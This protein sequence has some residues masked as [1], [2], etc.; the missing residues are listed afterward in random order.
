MGEITDDDPD[1]NAS[2]AALAD[3]ARDDPDL[4]PHADIFDAAEPL[5]PPLRDTPVIIDTDIGGDPD[6]A[7]ALIAAAYT[8]PTLAMVTTTDEHNGER[9][10]LARHLLDVLDRPDVDVVAG[11]P[12]RSRYFCAEGLVPASVPFQPGGVAEAVHTLCTSTDGPVR[13]VGMGPLSNL[14]AVLTA[15]PHLAEQLVVTQMGGGLNYRD[16]TRAEHNIRLDPDAARAALR[17]AHRPRLVT[18][19]VTFT[20]DIEITAGSDRYRMLAEADAPWAGLLRAHMD[21]WFA[22]FHPGTMQ[23][24]GLTLAAALHL[25]FLD[26]A[27]HRVA[28]DAA[29][30]MRDEPDGAPVRM[31][32]GADYPAFMTWL[33]DALRLPAQQV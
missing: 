32:V 4:R 29:G 28:L 9:A 23:H 13:W 26:F 21:R 3:H 33:A 25:P 8:V 19:D 22:D 11:P 20:A 18:S 24:D 17:L 31:S 6:D 7:V 27:R 15:H 12:G 1:V 2:R 5:S 10:R 14:A 16:P 30:R